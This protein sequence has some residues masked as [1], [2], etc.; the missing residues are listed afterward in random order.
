MF[1]T[2]FTA[3]CAAAAIT[4]FAET[5]EPVGYW[6]LD[7]GEG[8]VIKS[9]V[10]GVPAGSV[11]NAQNTKWV[12]GRKGGK[13]LY[14]CGDP[15]KKRVGGCV[16]VPSKSFFDNTKPFTIT[17]WVMPESRKV[18]KREANYEL[19]S[20]TV[21]DRGPGLRIC[22]AWNLASILSGDGKKS[23][24]MTASE[25]KFPVKRSVWSHIALAY[26]GKVLKLYV[27]GA[28]ANSK[29]MAV[30]KGRDYFCIG[31]YSTGSAYSFMGAISD[32]KFY[33]VELSAGQVM[34]EA[35]DLS[36]EE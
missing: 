29:E 23:N 2:L 27:N 11:F 6:K 26:D 4:A 32:V 28:L 21:S 3:L 31:S 30:T 12:D 19:V 9:S 33:N 24:G 25:A 16:R 35:K 13:A 20:N 17:F 7:D 10:A 1:K 5:P 8:K 18:M 22:L 14:F 36:D 15:T 34:A